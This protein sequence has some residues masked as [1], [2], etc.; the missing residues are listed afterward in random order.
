MPIQLA[1]M[2]PQGIS[3]ELCAAALLVV[4]A[5][6]IAVVVFFGARRMDEKAKRELDSVGTEAGLHTAGFDLS[7]MASQLFPPPDV[8][9]YMVKARSGLLRYTPLRAFEGLVKGRKLEAGYMTVRYGKEPLMHDKIDALYVCTKAGNKLYKNVV[10]TSW[11]VKWATFAF[12]VDAPRRM[13]QQIIE[14]LGVPAL[15]ETGDAK[16]DQAVFIFASDRAKG[17]NILPH[18]VLHKV[19]KTLDEMPYEKTLL[20]VNGDSVYLVIFRSKTDSEEMKR[21]IAALSI[22]ADALDEIK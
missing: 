19:K 10:F 17:R 2:L 5:L 15:V 22:I 14:R 13:A 8:L 18:E 4:G 9:E 11:E 7:P 16:L 1:A 12:S 21:A 3:S 20:A 6:V